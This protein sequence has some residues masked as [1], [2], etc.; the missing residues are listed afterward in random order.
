MDMRSHR[1]RERGVVR[2]ESVVLAALGLDSQEEHA[3]R[4]LF[5]VLSATSEEVQTALGLEPTRAR[6]VLARLEEL[7]FIYRL[8]DAPVRFASAPGM[9]GAAITRKLAGLTDEAIAAHLKVSVRTVERKTRALM[10]AAEVRTRMQ[11][12]WKAAQRHWL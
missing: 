6:A 3:Y 1:L 9:V 10:D 12:A 11:L 5:S 8:T 4:Y 7:G 2:R